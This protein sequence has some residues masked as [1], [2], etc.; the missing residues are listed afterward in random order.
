MKM[1][2]EEQHIDFMEAYDYATRMRHKWC[3]GEEMEVIDYI[4][5]DLPFPSTDMDFKVI[6]EIR[7]C[8][9]CGEI[10]EFEL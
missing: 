5:K 1:T 6:G 7:E 8:R 2:F 4:T 9:I 3:H 10:E